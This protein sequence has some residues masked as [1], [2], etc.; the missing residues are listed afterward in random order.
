MSSGNMNRETIQTVEK[1]GAQPDR[2]GWWRK[3]RKIYLSL[4]ICWNL[5][6]AILWLTPPNDFRDRMLV[7]FR[8]YM[9]YLGLWQCYVVFAPRPRSFNL[10]LTATIW[11]KDGTRSEYK[12]PNP[13]DYNQFERM[14]K[15]RY[16]K[17]VIDNLNSDDNKF[18]WPDAAKWIARMY[19]TPENPPVKVELVRHWTDVMPPGCDT[20]VGESH[21]YKF[22]SYIP[23]P[24]DLP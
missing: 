12:L 9:W 7:A 19:Y 22:F 20:T 6:G 17:Y 14:T 1:T 16:R 18:L 4:F 24:G 2:F 21:T 10:Y 13:P 11:K 15:E 8:P 5:A 23:A 3:Y